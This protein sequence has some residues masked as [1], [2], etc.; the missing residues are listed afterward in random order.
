MSAGRAIIIEL[1]AIVV[2]LALGLYAIED[3]S[4]GAE[5]VFLGVVLGLIGLFIYSVDAD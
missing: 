1:F 5:G 4:T 2:T 3:A